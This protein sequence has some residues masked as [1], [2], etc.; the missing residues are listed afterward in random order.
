[1]CW[2]KLAS[3]LN[4]CL[5]YGRSFAKVEGGRPLGMHFD[6]DDNLLICNAGVV[7][8]TAGWRL[9]GLCLQSCTSM[10]HCKRLVSA[11]VHVKSC[12]RAHSVFCAGLAAGG[13]GEQQG[14]NPCSTHQQGE[15]PQP[16]TLH[17]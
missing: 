3:C 1:M 13:E 15:Q 7:S 6:K 10:Q 5:L 4:N 11:A 16:I 14:H 12:T 17:C 9:A 2:F 8:L